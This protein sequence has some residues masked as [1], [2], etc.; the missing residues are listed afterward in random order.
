MR[1]E[2]RRSIASSSARSSRSSCGGCDLGRERLELGPDEE[3]L[4]EL[5]GEIERTRTPRF[6]SNDTSPS[7]ARRRS[8][9][10]T[11]VRLTTN[12][13]ESCSWRSTVPGR[14]RR[15]RRSRPR[16]PGDVVGLGRERR[17][18][19]S[20][21][22]ATIRIRSRSLSDPKRRQI[23]LLACTYLRHLGSENCQ[24]WI[25]K[26]ASDE[27]RPR[28]HDAP[29]PPPTSSACAARSTSSTRSR[30][31]APSGCGCC[32]HERRL[33]PRARRADRRSGRADGQGRPARRS[34]SR[35]GRSQPT[36]T[37]PAG[38]YPDQSLYP[39]NSGPG[40]RASGSTTRCCAPTRSRTPRATTST[41]WL[42]PIVADAEAGFGGPLN[43][44]EMMKC[45]HRGGRCGRALRG[46]ALVREEVRPPRRQGA[47]PDQ[48]V[49]P[50]A[51]R[52][53]PGRRR[54]RRADADRRPHRRALRVAAHERHRRGRP[55]VRAP[56]SGRREGFF[57][58]RDG[59]DAAIARGLAYA[60]VRRPHLVRDLDARHGRGRAVRR[61]RS[62]SSTPTGCSPTTARRRSTGAGT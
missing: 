27:L 55:R 35:A 21:R 2:N 33:G 30:A 19:D 61:R 42:A 58:V 25:R 57:R 5:G 8:A 4:A 37:S 14:D 9:S 26:E 39:A 49:R 11:G 7:A 43:A 44:F 51:R 31:S 28:R 24:F 13:S 34:T 18:P 12:R 40:A 54:A 62:T 45:V 36:R 16:G 10:R 22:P 3:R 50:H 17:H 23:W 6:G 20:L 38:T 1:A 41:H 59:I 47:H 60:P 29:T 46:P 15:R 53:A 48:P 32:S 56:A 52:G